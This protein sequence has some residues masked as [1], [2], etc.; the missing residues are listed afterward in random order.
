MPGPAQVWGGGTRG[1]A[2]DHRCTSSPAQGLVSVFFL[3]TF[4]LQR[5]LVCSYIRSFRIPL[6]IYWS[7][8]NKNTRCDR[9]GRVPV[10]RSGEPCGEVPEWQR[11][12]QWLPGLLPGTEGGTT[13]RRLGLGLI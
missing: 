13:Q 3:F 5:L 11:W 9:V 2:L 8:F 1:A 12:H 10:F 6:D 4:L 7:S